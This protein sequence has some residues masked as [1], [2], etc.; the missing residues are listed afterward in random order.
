MKQK[1]VDSTAAAGTSRHNPAGRETTDQIA[2]AAQAAGDN[3]KV[4]KDSLLWSKDRFDR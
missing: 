4:C 3:R 2:V 1:R